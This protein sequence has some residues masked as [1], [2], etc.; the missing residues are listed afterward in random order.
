MFAGIF[1][2]IMSSRVHFQVRAAHEPPVAVLGHAF[3]SFDTSMNYLVLIELT[4]KAE[5]FSTCFA[6]KFFGLLVFVEV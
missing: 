6:N 3:V 2:F 4:H 5:F 1:Y